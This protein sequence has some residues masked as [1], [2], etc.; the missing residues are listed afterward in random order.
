M[1]RSGPSERWQIRIEKS[2][3]VRGFDHANTGGAL[4]LPNL[5]TKCLH[6]CPMNFWPEM[7]FGVVT[8]VE[9]GPVIEFV[10]A[11]HA[12]GERLVRITAIMPVE[13]VQVRQAV[14]EIIKRKKETDVMP[15]EN[16]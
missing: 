9:P 12:P 7:M 2:K 1:H 10:I 6:A 8:V 5:I 15:V 13:P 11:A 16:A 3:C 4:L 14:P